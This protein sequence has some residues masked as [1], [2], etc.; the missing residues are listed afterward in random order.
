LKFNQRKVTFDWIVGLIFNIIGWILLASIASSFIMLFKLPSPKI[1]S[2]L[3][4]SMAI[5]FFFLVIISSIFF[6]KGRMMLARVKT[7]KMYTAILSVDPT[8]SIERIAAS[9]EI[10]KVKF[11]QSSSSD[12][13]QFVQDCIINMINHGYFPKG[14][15]IDP[16]KKAIVFPAAPGKTTTSPVTAEEYITFTCKN[17]GASNKIVKSSENECAYCGTL[18]NFE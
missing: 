17:C 8:N 6:S 1:V 10:P 5:T 15:F 2:S 13:T 14:T 18:F 9:T 4:P 11:I 3:T 16:E 12:K 7:F